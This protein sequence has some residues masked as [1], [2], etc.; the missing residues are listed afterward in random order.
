MRLRNTEWI[1]LLAFLWFAVLASCV[2]RLGGARRRT[3]RL[4][5]AAGVAITLFVSLVL[6]QFTSGRTASITRDWIPLLLLALFYWQGGQFV[7][8][9]DAAVEEKLARLDLQFVAPLFER[10]LRSSFRNGIFIFVETGYLSYY[11]VMPLGIVALYLQGLPGE[12]DFFWTVVLLAAYGS[13]STLPFLNLRP[14]RF[15]G[16]KWSAGLPQGKIRALNLWILRLGS[17]SSNTCPSAHVAIGMACALVMFR[18]A[19]LW[20]G[21]LFLG[22]AVSIAIGAVG[23][24]YH[25][26]TDAVLGAAAAVVAFL[27]GT[28]AAK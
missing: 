2:R 19:P 23:G 8:G 12:V 24:R 21:M 25:Y 10:S 5:G 1:N 17:I 15:I 9:I 13:C 3:I 7:T 16:E 20:L 22:V 18:L 14:P 27:I 4:I 6:P 26:V 11:L 28:V